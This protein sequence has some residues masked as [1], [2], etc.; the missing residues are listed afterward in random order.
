MIL[1]NR[2]VWSTGLLE[3]TEER[4]TENI[5]LR[6]RGI[7]MANLREAGSHSFG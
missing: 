3:T 1:S 7:L 5:R 4:A 2:V 6:R